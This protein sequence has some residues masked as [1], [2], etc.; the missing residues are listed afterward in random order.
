VPLTHAACT[1][2]K[3]TLAK[4]W[5]WQQ[6]WSKRRTPLQS[7]FQNWTKLHT[8]IR[9]LDRIVRAHPAPSRVSTKDSSM[10]LNTKTREVTGRS[11]RAARD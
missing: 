7:A 10:P 9:S 8:I 1:A 11:D 2:H 3:P 4:H 5:L 6:A